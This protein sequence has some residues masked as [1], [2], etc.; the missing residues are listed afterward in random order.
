MKPPKY[1]SPPLS[2]C[3]SFFHWIMGIHSPSQEMR[4]SLSG[5]LNRAERRYCAKVKAYHKDMA[6]Y[7]IATRTMSRNEWKSH[8]TA[9]RQKRR[10]G[11]FNG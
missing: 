5:P 3:G 4:L 9:E 7:K 8:H 6:R 2:M 11:V 1:P 10:T